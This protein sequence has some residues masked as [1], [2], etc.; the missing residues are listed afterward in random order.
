VV[1]HPEG[2]SPL[3]T[4]TS[5]GD[6]ST[7]SYLQGHGSPCTPGY[8]HYNPHGLGGAGLALSQPWV[9][10]E[11]AKPHKPRKHARSGGV[12]IAKTPAAASALKKPRKTVYTCTECGQP[13]K[14]HK[15]PYAWPNVKYPY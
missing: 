11:P 6:T 10:D 15:C 4:Q 9:P 1:I 7:A 8:E 2:A 14:G 13:K 3:R 12:G 5:F